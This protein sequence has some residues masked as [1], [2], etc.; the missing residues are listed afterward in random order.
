MPYTGLDTLVEVDVE[1]ASAS[2][3]TYQ[4]GG[5][6]QCP[7]AA[8]GDTEVDYVPLPDGDPDSTVR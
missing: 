3:L 4:N 1:V 7:H 5:Q 2:G 8:G 6:C